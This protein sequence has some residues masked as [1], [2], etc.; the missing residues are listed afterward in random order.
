MYL[1]PVL[2][3][4]SPRPQ[5]ESSPW[6]PQLESAR[7]EGLGQPRLNKYIHMYVNKNELPVLPSALERTGREGGWERL[8]EALKDPDKR[9]GA[10]KDRQGLSLSRGWTVK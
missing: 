9:K 4:S 8:L 10:A 7:T 6:F 5:L 3:K 1:E 2:C